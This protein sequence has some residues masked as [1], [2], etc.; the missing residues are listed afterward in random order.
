MVNAVF[1]LKVHYSLYYTFP[2]FFTYKSFLYILPNIKRN[3]TVVR[4]DNFIILP[5]LIIY[6]DYLFNKTQ[7]DR[8]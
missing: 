5:Y 1:F 7:P 4:I 2:K 3:K 8:I 6:N